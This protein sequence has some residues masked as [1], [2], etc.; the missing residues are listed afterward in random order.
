M[1][2]ELISAQ[3]VVGVSFIVTILTLSCCLKLLR[4][5]L[6]SHLAQKQAGAMPSSAPSRALRS[7]S[8]DV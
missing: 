6:S 3:R 1:C 5:A 8:L 2:F 7:V 4:A